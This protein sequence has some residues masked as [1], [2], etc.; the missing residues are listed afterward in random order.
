MLEKITML[1]DDFACRELTE[2]VRE[3]LDAEDMLA[4][5]RHEQLFVSL[6]R[7]QTSRKQQK[8]RARVVLGIAAVA[9][10]AVLSVA[11]AMLM[12][13]GELAFR[14]GNEGRTF[15][16]GEPGTWVQADLGETMEIRFDQGSRFKVN[17]GCAARVVE[18]GQQAVTIE[19]SKG[20]IS[21]DV[22]GNKRT[23]WKINAGP[24][25]VTVLG[26]AF[27]VSWDAASTDFDVNVRRGAVLVQGAGLSRYGVR[28]L[29]GQRLAANGRSGDV[30]MSSP[31]HIAGG[32]DSR[33]SGIEMSGDSVDSTDE[34]DT[35]SSELIDR[36]KRVGKDQSSRGGKRPWVA[37]YR[38]GRFE[39]AISAA[40]KEG[41]S[42][43]Y[44]TADAQTL[45]N[46]ADAARNARRVGI[47]NDSLLALR[48]RFPA[49]RKAK[50]AAFIIGRSAMDVSGNLSVATQWFQMYLTESPNGPMVEE[51]HGRLMTVYS[52]MNRPAAAKRIAA[53]Y[54]QRYP[55]GLYAG[56]AKQVLQ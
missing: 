44:G 39:D 37:L 17:D 42:K 55:G 52:R 15:V 43:M 54:L 45:W 25:T 29:A 5:K 34:H 1:D 11:A 23:R 8:K 32:T 46:L 14:V 40:E 19:L 13:P 51:V 22:K 49:S 26:T 53:Q 27:D 33:L 10:V 50:L 56:R 36:D 4:S 18:S 24:F 30:S 41:L 48:K 3:H 9:A 31:Q 16:P 28:L 2:I 21:A 47:S 35:L 20:D 7:N 12:A 38:Q 6:V